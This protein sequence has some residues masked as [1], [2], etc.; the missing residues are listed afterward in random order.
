MS[1]KMP[2]NT[3]SK[4]AWQRMLS[5]RRLNLIDPSPLDIEI[6][7]IA[8]GLSRVAR[9]NGQT[10]G[11]HAFSVAEHSLLVEK[12]FTLQNPNSTLSDQLAALLHDAAEY[13]IGD[14]ISPFKAA[15]GIN[16]KSFELQLEEAINIRFSLPAI[17]N[18]KLQKKIK[19]SDLYS[20]WFEATQIAGFTIPE[21]NRFFLKPPPSLKIK[22]KPIAVG[23]VEKAFLNRFNELNKTSY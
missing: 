20:A 8:R 2:K 1:E 15:L 7:D 6:E 13:V 21:A 3:K 22:I 16:Y 23:F 9:W 12:I 18:A 5:G 17:K 11:I 4:R 10:S 19:Q 14:M